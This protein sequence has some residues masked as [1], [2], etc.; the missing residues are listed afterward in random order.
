MRLIEKER[1]RNFSFDRFMNRTSPLMKLFFACVLVV[2]LGILI[3]SLKIFAI[4][5]F[6]IVFIYAAYFVFWIKDN[7]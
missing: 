3:T 5:G 2:F 7:Y 4:A 1:M 6:M